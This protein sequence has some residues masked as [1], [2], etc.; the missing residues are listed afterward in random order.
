M[1]SDSFNIAITLR[2]VTECER[3]ASMSVRIFGWVE[4][5]C[6]AEDSCVE[7]VS[8]RITDVNIA[9]LLT[10]SGRTRGMV[11]FSASPGQERVG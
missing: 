8:A 1:T 11:R 7:I 9:R 4:G 6:D 2:N 3:P 10:R 5:K